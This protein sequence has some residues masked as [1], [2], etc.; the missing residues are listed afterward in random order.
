MSAAYTPR[1]KVLLMVEHMR[2]EPDR[3]FTREDLAPVAGIEPAMSVSAYLGAARKNGPVH[4]RRNGHVYVYRVN[5]FEPD[6]DAAP[7]PEFK[8]AL[9]S[10]GDVVLTGA[11]I[12]TDNSILLAPAHVAV[13]RKLLAVDLRPAA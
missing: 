11:T 5:P 10:D 2:K 6:P 9:W 4:A 1:G 12:C 13:L 7:P 8:C 3:E